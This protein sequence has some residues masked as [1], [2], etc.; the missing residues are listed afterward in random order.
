M[1]NTIIINLFGGPG[2]GK[3]TCAAYLFSRLKMLGID[4]EYVSEFAKDKVWEQNKKVFNNQL[5]ITGKQSFK[6]S[7]CFGEVDV[8]INDSPIL[9]GCAYT[10]R[11]YLKS[12]IVE[13]FMSYADNNVNFLLKRKKVYNPNGRNQTEEEAHKL[14]KKILSILNLEEIKTEY[15]HIDYIEVD[16]NE[17]GF[18]KILY[19]ICEILESIKENN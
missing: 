7:R 19:S 5:Y 3:S 10:D 6:I 13:E 12:A 11:K 15:D 9:N 17:D 8:I 4:A 16:G 1:K 14:D 2:T 18:N